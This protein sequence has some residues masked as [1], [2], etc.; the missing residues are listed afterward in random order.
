M[1]QQL[2]YLLVLMEIKLI[3]KQNFFHL[4]GKKRFH[5]KSSKNLDKADELGIEMGKTLK[6]NLIILIKNNMHILFTRPIEDCHEMILKFQSLG[7]KVSHL[8]LIRY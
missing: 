3:L 2:E 5:L 6:K 4:D 7:H 8:P 1:K